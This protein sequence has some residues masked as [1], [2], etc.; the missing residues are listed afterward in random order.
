MTNITLNMLNN[1]KLLLTLNQGTTENTA[2]SK[3]VSSCSRAVLHVLQGWP[4]QAS[5]N[6]HL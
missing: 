4:L 6:A 3:S 5:A 2:I 1:P